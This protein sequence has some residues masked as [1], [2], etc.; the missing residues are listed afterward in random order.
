M[1]VVVDTGLGNV[2]SVV[3]MCSRLNIAVMRSGKPADVRSATALILPGVGAFDAGIAKLTELKLIEPLNERVMSAKVPVLG[4][5][6]GMQLMTRSSE[7]GR[8]AGLGWVPAQ[9]RSIKNLSANNA[10]RLRLPHIG[11]NYVRRV[12]EH[13]ITQGFDEETRFYFVHSF[14]TVCD[15]ERDVLLQTSYAGIP[16]AAGF[17]RENVIGMQFHPEK[18]HKFGMQVFRNF[19]EWCRRA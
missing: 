19:S 17:A 12:K 4:I 10:E 1:L 8:S 16:F 14:A 15:D 2:G 5:C 18:S 11:W 9:T 13:P 6:L 3:N 7:E